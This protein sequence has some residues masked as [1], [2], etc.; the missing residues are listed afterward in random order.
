VNPVFDAL[1]TLLV[2]APMAAILAFTCWISYLVV[3][4]GWR[5]NRIIVPPGQ[6][7][8]EVAVATD[9][10]A[11]RQRAVTRTNRASRP[12]PSRSRQRT[13]RRR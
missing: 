11:V 2:L 6:P 12:A 7:E 9:T 4:K 5:T 8:A 3:I 1:L 13:R 10:P